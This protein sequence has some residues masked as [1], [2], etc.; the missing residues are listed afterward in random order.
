VQRLHCVGVG[1]VDLRKFTV[2]YDVHAV[3]R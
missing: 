1:A 3:R 2:A